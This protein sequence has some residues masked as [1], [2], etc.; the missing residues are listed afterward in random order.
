[1]AGA[2]SPLQDRAR[3]SLADRGIKRPDP[4]QVVAEMKR[5]ES[6]PEGPS[7]PVSIFGRLKKAC[8]G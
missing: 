3:R 4:S 1:M 5:I 2:M 6:V 7:D 8:G